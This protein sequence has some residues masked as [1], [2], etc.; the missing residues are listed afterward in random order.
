MARAWTRSVP[1][2]ER[3]VGLHQTVQEIVR[4]GVRTVS[5]GKEQDPGDGMQSPWLIGAI[6]NRFWSIDS[7]NDRSNTNTFFTNAYPSYNLPDG[8]YLTSSPIITAMHP[9]ALVVSKSDSWTWLRA[10]TAIT[11]RPSSTGCNYNPNT[12]TRTAAKPNGAT[13]S[14]SISRV[15]VIGVSCV[16]FTAWIGEEKK[17]GRIE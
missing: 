13:P 15:V 11:K 8:W 10:E 17:S 6:F 7:N 14:V 3:P 16:L 5:A 12:T 9:G 2:K 4:E 1:E